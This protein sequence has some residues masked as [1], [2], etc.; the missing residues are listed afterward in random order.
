MFAVVST[1]ASCSGLHSMAPEC[2]VP[3]LSMITTSRVA[4]SGSNKPRYSSRD[5]VAGKPGPPSVA[6]SVPS[7][8]PPPLC[9]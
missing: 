5:S 9:G 3:R 1:A 2:P 4:R 7:A 6:T 8:A